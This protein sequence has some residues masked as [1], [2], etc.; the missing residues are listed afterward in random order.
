MRWGTHHAAAAAAKAIQV[1]GEADWRAI[2]R[3]TFAC[4]LSAFRSACTIAAIASELCQHRN[5]VSPNQELETDFL[6]RQTNTHS[7]PG[8]QPKLQPTAIRS[9]PQIL[10]PRKHRERRL[11][12]TQYALRRRV[13]ATFQKFRRRAQDVGWSFGQGA[14][15]R[16]PFLASCMHP[17]SRLLWL[18]MSQTPHS[19]G[20]TQRL[21]R[22]G[23]RPTGRRP[24]TLH[25]QQRRA[26]VSV[27]A[28]AHAVEFVSAIASL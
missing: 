18:A 7:C 1:R 2:T 17:P 8:Y 23:A 5:V 6:T 22:G 15:S 27:Q 14:S 3:Y 4:P 19:Q 26:R 10:Q 16:P 12:L 21:S 11:V 28:D 13:H 24:R 20:F 25:L 9:A